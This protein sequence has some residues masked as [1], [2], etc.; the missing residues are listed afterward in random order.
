M[1]LPEIVID[2]ESELH[3]SD[4]KSLKRINV[5]GL[6]HGAV[7][8]AAHGYAARHLEH[9]PNGMLTMSTGTALMP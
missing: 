2:K 7:Q 6:A 8:H 5:L 4:K 3:F 1:K 9:L